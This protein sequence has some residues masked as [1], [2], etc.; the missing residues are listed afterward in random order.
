MPNKAYLEITNV[1]NLNCRFCHGTTRPRHFM[2]VEEF[3]TA[4]GRLRPFADYLYFH[5]MG[6]PLLHPRLADFFE[7]ADSLGFKVIITTNG[8]LLGEKHSLLLSVPALHKISVSL[9]SFEAND[10]I[11]DFDGYIDGCLEFSDAASERGIICVLR[12][13]NIGGE[14][15]SNDALLERLHCRFPSPW[16]ETRTGFK[17]KERLFLEWGKHFEWPDIDLPAIGGNHRCYGLRDQVGVLCDGTVVPCCLD[18][19]GVIKLG[20]IFEN[21]IETILQTERA[22]SLKAQLQCGKVIEPLCI[23]CGFAADKFSTNLQSD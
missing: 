23:R 18:A 15:A 5:L 10:G 9:H 20:N 8:T 19:E 6:E 11:R 17:I 13:W 2:T 12:L 1:C 3:T 22:A 14:N 7:I 21:D 16:T 4:A